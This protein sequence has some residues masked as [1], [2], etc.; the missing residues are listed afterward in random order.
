MASSLIASFSR[1]PISEQDP[2]YSLEDVRS[3]NLWGQGLSDL[4]I[5][6][7]MPNIEVLS[8]SVNKITSLAAFANCTRLQELYLRKNEVL[9]HSR[10]LG[11]AATGIRVGCG[12][13]QHVEADHLQILKQS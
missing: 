11:K 12:V 6:T 7:K 9:N 5:V 4:S 8:L 1:G 3:L 10:C 2:F 13:A